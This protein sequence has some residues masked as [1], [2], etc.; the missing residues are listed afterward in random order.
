VRTF[1]TAVV[2]LGGIA[3]EWLPP[4]LARDD[5]DLVALVD[6]DRARAE[7]Q[8]ATF[9]LRAPVHTDL[10]TAMSAGAVDL[11]INLTPP[12]F[13]REIS[14]TALAAGCDVIVEKPLTDELSDAVAIVLA[15][16]AAGR[17]VAVMQ[18]RRYHPAVRRM[19]AGLAAGEIGDLVDTSVDMFL[20]HIYSNPYL[21]RTDSPLLRDMAIHQFDAARAITGA[22]AVRVQTLEWSSPTSWMPGATA[23]S[24]TFELSN[25]TVFSYR[26]S[27]VAEGAFTSY[28]GAWRVGG[29]RG[30]FSWDGEAQL[31]VETV[32]RTRGQHAAGVRTTI[33]EDVPRLDR[34]GHPSG[35]NAI[36]DALAAGETAETVCDDNLLSL[37]MVDAAVRSSRE[38][39]TIEIDDVLADA[40]WSG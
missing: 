16:K 2:G 3:K 14:E 18:N 33:A 37:A 31:V 29:T 6:P 28:D 23:A 15:A 22:N 36:L 39:R 13:H 10:G 38:R 25:G 19:R 40:G 12:G 5:V 35:L 27:W 4:L 26:G 24:A 7:G 11:V 32:D 9:G 1:R 34:I 21:M 20:W 8:R 17:T 30:S